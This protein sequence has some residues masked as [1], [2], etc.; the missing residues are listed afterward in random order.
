MSIQPPSDIILDVA[1]AADP[2]KS[3]AATQR[4]MQVGASSDT[5]AAFS[6]VLENISPNNISPNNISLSAGPLMGLGSRL[7]SSGNFAKAPIINGPVDAR[8]KAYKG[9]EALILQNLFETTLPH[10]SSLGEGMAG[11]VFRSMLAEQ[12]G[13]QLGKTMDLGITPKTTSSHPNIL[14]SATTHN[15]ADDLSFLLN[16]PE[17]LGGGV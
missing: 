8:S 12:L 14:Q 17:T 16:D 3:L 7:G 13:K 4:L 11:D 5:G 1:Q 10:D 15:L 9:L 6:G 2:S